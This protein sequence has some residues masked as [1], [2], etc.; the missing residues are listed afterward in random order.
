[1]KT[2]SFG[3]RL[4]ALRL[5]R[6]MTVAYFADQIQVPKSTYAEWESGRQIQGEPYVR[7]AE[8]C[9]ISLHELFT[10]EKPE[11]NQLIRNFDLIDSQFRDFR[12]KLLSFL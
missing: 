10:G 2:E 4:R 3:S 6:N 11:L 5:E 12:N 9:K 7:I 1:M 8:V